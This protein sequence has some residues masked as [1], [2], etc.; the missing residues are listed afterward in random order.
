MGTGSTGDLVPCLRLGAALT[1]R[2]HDVIAI[3]LEGY[4]PARRQ[5]FEVRTIPGAD[6]ALW[7]TNPIARD[8]ALANPGVMYLS[9]RRKLA[10]LAPQVNELLCRLVTPDTTLVSNLVTMEAGRLLATLRGARHATLLFAPL[11]PATT[12]ASNTFIPRPLSGPVGAALSRGMWALTRELGGAYAEDLRGRVRA[13]DRI[14]ART[15]TVLMAT[16]P[17]VSPPSPRWPD[18][19][20]QTG[21]F[22]PDLAQASPL[23]PGLT[24][25]LDRH[26]APLL[27]S[28]GSCAIA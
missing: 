16:S 25:F 13:P 1:A 2:G 5:P 10:Q 7:P 19:V 26:P 27:M 14:D 3:A 18:S 4:L 24:E 20:R 15:T 22:G 8:L 28:F 12:A 11:L 9:M 6:D 23:S 17:L 21:W